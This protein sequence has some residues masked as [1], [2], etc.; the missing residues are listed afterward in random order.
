VQLRVIHSNSNWE[1]VSVTSQVA[2]SIP[3]KLIATARVTIIFLNNG[4][5]RP[6][7]ACRV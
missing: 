3:I 5:R 1:G 6:Q 7:K 4:H 2:I